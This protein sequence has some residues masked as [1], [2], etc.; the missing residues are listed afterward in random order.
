PSTSFMVLLFIIAATIGAYDVMEWQCNS[1][2]DDEQK[3]TEAVEACCR[4]R[5]LSGGKCKTEEYHSNPGGGGFGMSIN[6]AYCY[7]A[8][9]P[10]VHY[11]PFVI[12]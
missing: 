1:A 11:P 3:S 9:P 8:P 7:Q 2:C 6:T 5:G 10:A 12:P 4:D